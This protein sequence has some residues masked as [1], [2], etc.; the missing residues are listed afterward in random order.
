MS[1]YE[2]ICNAFLYTQSFMKVQ[3][4]ITVLSFVAF[5]FASCS[6][7]NQ[8]KEQ[9]YVLHYD[10]PAAFFEESLPLGNGQLGAL[11]YGGVAEEK[12]SLNDI[13]LWTGEPDLTPWSP[14]AWKELAKVRQLLDQEDYAAANEANK[15]LQGH[16]SEIYQ[17]LGQ[18]CLTD[19][20]A[21]EDYSDYQRQLTLNDALATITYT[22]G[23]I[24]QSRE[25]F[26]SAPDSVIVIRLK[27][28]GENGLIYRVGLSSLLPHKYAVEN[29]ALW[30][31]GYAAYSTKPEAGKN[32]W[33]H[34][35]ENR[36][37][38]FR[39][40]LRIV[41]PEG[42]VS[43]DSDTTLVVK[44]C[45][46]AM[47]LLTNATSYNGPYNDPVK[48]GRDYRSAVAKRLEKAEQKNY[49]QLYERHQA[50]FKSFFGRVSLDLGTTPDSIAALPTD[51]QLLAYAYPDAVFNPDLEELYF[52]YGRYL[53]ISSSRTEGVPANLQ[54]LWNETLTPPWSGNYT[55]NINVEENYWPAETTA[56]PEMHNSFLT[57]VKNMPKSGAITAKNYYGIEDNSSIHTPLPSAK[58]SSSRQEHKNALS[59]AAR[60]SLSFAPW[61]LNHN[62]DIWNMTNP[63]GYQ[64]ESPE[65]ACWPIGGAWVSTHLWEHYS[66]TQDKAFLR[67]YYPIMKGAVR[68]FQQW[69]VEKNGN[70][71]TSPSTSPENHYLTDKGVNSTTLYG[72]TADVAMIRELLIDT[73]KAALIVSEESML[74]AGERLFADTLLDIICQL[75]P[76]KVGKKGNL[77]EWYYDWEDA[78]P[79]HRHQSHLFGLYPGHHINDFDTPDLMQ[80][81]AKTLEIKGDQTTGWSSGWRVNLQAHLHNAD[82]AYH[83]LRKLLRYVSP[84]GR[85]DP[86]KQWGGG[87]T[88]PNLFDA[89]P[90]FQIDG[91]F[92][93]T[94]G[95]A[96]MLV[97]S[98]DEGR[99]DLLPALPAVWSKQGEINGVRLRGGYELSMA[100]TE[101]KLTRLEIKNL[102]AGDG[103]LLFRTPDGEF[104]VE[105]KTKENVNVQL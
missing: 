40:E 48:C 64:K 8:Q 51:Q 102:Y 47:I 100:W 28:D 101:G 24:S 45:Q 54:G 46:E 37:I 3:K 20:S 70:L 56:L 53:L 73:R 88:Y 66:F 77:Q 76:Y 95:I 49:A 25:Y 19:L 71:M 55:V 30:T 17:A 10:R 16:N 80:A 72:G 12:I 99:V 105:I 32:E 35:D 41:A 65:W 103:T 93:G 83:I 62:S 52:Q 74:M 104:V 89:H 26:V 11:I 87:G 97:Q 75:E 91:N 39:T 7:Q 14:D 33:F 84:E 86:A 42:C 23:N 21:T 27:T 43:A 60:T 34:Y 15:K 29:N 36:G 13:T 68:F 57:W 67:E 9:A 2:Y 59:M 38:H 79:Q 92:G 85:D 58:A 81:C 94:A 1:K 78:D 63:V 82:E 31:E 22:I 6:E 90:P 44:G 18:L 50:D 96:E 98:T 61:C 69:L 5:A 4:Y